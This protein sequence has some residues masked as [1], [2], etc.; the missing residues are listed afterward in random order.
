MFRG[1]RLR[2]P[3][4]GRNAVPSDVLVLLFL[5]LYNA[6]F[7]IEDDGISTLERVPVEHVQQ[8]IGRMSRGTTRLGWC[9]DRILA[10]SRLLVG[11]FPLLICVNIIFIIDYRLHVEESVIKVLGIT[12]IRW[13]NRGD[14]WGC[15][16]DQDIV[17]QVEEQYERI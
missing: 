1:D 7:I 6:F 16:E 11:L 3:I 2:D 13:V 10:V 5:L 4:E 12:C 14:I 15:A 17:P 8:V 9:C